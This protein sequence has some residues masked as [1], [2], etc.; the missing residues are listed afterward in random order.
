MNGLERA[1]VYLGRPGI[2]E[3]Y[4]VNRSMWARAHVLGGLAIVGVVGWRLGASPF[5][6][7]VYTPSI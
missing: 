7:T 5:L 1:P 3:A 2:E 4:R 6:D